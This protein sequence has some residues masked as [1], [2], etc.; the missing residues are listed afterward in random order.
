MKE[1][2]AEEGEKKKSDE[3]TNPLVELAEG[4]SAFLPAVKVV[5]Y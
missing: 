3:Q 4:R 2:E 5:V 1:E